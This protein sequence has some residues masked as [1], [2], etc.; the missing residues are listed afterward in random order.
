MRLLHGVYF[1]I[2]AVVSV[3][4]GNPDAKR[5]Y[6]DLLS[7]YNKLVRPVVNVT[8]ALTVKIKLKLSQL[9]DVNL[10]NQIMTTNLWVE[11][12]W[13]DY[14]LKWE[15]KEYGGVEMLHVPSDHIWRPDIV[16]YNNA[17]G[18]FEV[19]LATKATLNYTG[20]VEW[21]PPAIYK[22]SCEIDVEY[23]P[24]DEQTCVMK[25]GSWTYDGFQVDLRHI[26]EMNET[27]V[28]E[29]GVDL[30]E[31]YTSV[32]WDILEVPA[33]RNEK[34]YT[35]CDEPYLDITFNITMRR[36]TLFYTVNLI[37]PCMGIS[38]LTI[39]V[40]YLPSDSGEKVSLSIS[41]LLSLT[42]FFLLLAEIIPPTSLVV[43]LLGKFVLFTMIL[44][45]FSIC[46]TVIVLNI[47]F[48]S[49]QTHTMAP[50][51][52]TIFINHLP[53]LLVMRRPIYQPLHHFSAAS[54]RFMLRSC[55]SLG[56]HIPPLPPTIAF[57][58]SVLLDHHLLDSSESLNTCRLHGSP[59][60]LHNHRSGGGGRH[61]HHHHH[62]ALVRGMDLMDDMPLPY[63]DH[64]HHN[65]PMSP[66]N[67]NLLSAASTAVPNPAATNITANSTT[68]GA[69]GL[70]DP[71]SNFH[72]S[73]AAANTNDSKTGAGNL[74]LKT[75]SATGHLSCCNSLFLNDLQQAAAVTTGATTADLL[76]GDNGVAV[77]LNNNL[78]TNVLPSGMIINTTDT[79][80]TV[81]AG[82]GKGDK[83]GPNRNRWLECPELTKAMD[84]VTYI[85]DH[86]RKEEESSRVKEDWKYVAM[87]LDRLFLWIFTIAV[88]FGTAGIILQAPTLYDTRVPIDIKM[89]EIAT[90][91]A[92]PYIA[93]PIL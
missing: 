25:F 1:T 27:N 61:H 89:S 65:S 76:L 32:E 8:D 52:R 9:I 47:H 78:P 35:C 86:T 83:T 68:T 40:F 26:D 92:K 71:N 19:T 39:L 60:H 45:T 67:F 43:P 59:T 91:T 21:R 38:F 63:H 49:P 62:S 16:L 10:K 17:D 73:L 64:N 2:F 11:Q 15:P 55:N 53:K 66:I 28:V 14:K 33:V 77:P 42:V 18:N 41:I 46:V 80:T 56:D 12:T 57:D 84:G 74:L 30:S 51:V 75:A 58:P 24:F 54:Q 36:K 81:P 50:W 72:K 90:T 85:A 70:L 93:K 82:G 23:F 87:V 22:S 4:G 79:G 37:I 44:D 5:L 6:D 34:F 29:V 31:F 13:Y 88:V 7:N 20:R 48:R 69:G 3:C